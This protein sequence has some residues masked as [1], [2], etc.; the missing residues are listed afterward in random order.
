MVCAYL[1]ADTPVRSPS[2]GFPIFWAILPAVVVI[3]LAAAIIAAVKRW[4]GRSV[5]ERLSVSEQLSHFRTLYEA[6]ELSA[7]EFARIRTRLG[8]QLKQELEI[9]PGNGTDGTPSPP[10]AP[11]PDPNIRPGPPGT[12]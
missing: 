7:A 2:A 8:A 9:P 1:V 3:L 12:P 10:P 11:D 6:G 4:R 5:P